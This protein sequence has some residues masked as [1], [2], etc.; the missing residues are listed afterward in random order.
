MANAL[1][2]G[3]PVAIS[4]ARETE[5]ARLDLDVEYA[6]VCNRLYRL[7]ILS[8]LYRLIRYYLTG[9]IFADSEQPFAVRLDQAAARL[10]QAMDRC[11]FNDSGD[12]TE[13]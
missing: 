11:V 4:I 8:R 10:V 12:V 9:S 2:H 5:H 6:L 3:R 1:E 7:P 13:F